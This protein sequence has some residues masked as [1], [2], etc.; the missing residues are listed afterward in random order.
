[1]NRVFSLFLA[2]LL[3]APAILADDIGLDKARKAAEIFLT[4]GSPETRGSSCR[5]T[6]VNA[7]EV[8]AT[9][10]GNKPAYYIFNREGGGFV[11]ISAIDAA[12]PVLAYSFENSFGP[13]DQMPANV[14][15]WLKGYKSQ[16][17]SR[18]ISGKPA[19]AEESA[20]WNALMA[21]GRKALTG[22][23][24]DLQTADWGQGAPYNG[25]C[26]LDESGNRTVVGCTNTAISEVM[27]Y[28][29][30]P[31]AGT[32]TLPAYTSRFGST[33][34]DI[35]SVTLGEE[36]KWDKMLPNYSVASYT[37]EQADAV[38][39]LCYHVA[40]MT[41]A[42]FSAGATSASASKGVSRLTQYFGYDLGFTEYDSN[43]FSYDGWFQLIKDCI[44]RDLPV[45][46]TGYSED[47]GGHCF[48]V[49]GYD[50]A[51]RMLINFGWN[52][53]SNGYYEI[54]S[55][56]QYVLDNSCW[57][58]VHPDAG[59]ASNG[60]LYLNSNNSYSGLTYQSGTPAPGASI[61]VKFGIAYWRSNGASFNGTVNFKMMGRDGNDKCWVHSGLSSSLNN[62][63]GQYWSSV[64]L[65]IPSNVT[66]ERGDYIAAYYKD[67]NS[68]QWEPVKY[69]DAEVT[70]IGK[71]Y[72]HIADFT[73]MEFN[74]STR[75]LVFKTFSDASYTLK[76][77]SG[78]NVTSG[79]SYSGGKLTVDTRNL[80][81]GKYTVT[82]TSG[83]QSTTLSFK[84]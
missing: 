58:N 12:K 40:V 20:R 11:I 46:Y 7:S 83:S 6:L 41:Q 27:Y 63:Q 31:A 2:L 51:G 53:S 1:M 13:V 49:D 32:G 10:V 52:A 62:N 54:G 59:G 34:I 81:S 72:C 17:D 9:R 47:G 26:P 39:T 84:I 19:T 77:T 67:N 42:L 18:R 75:V 37:Q 66:I 57:V 33:V 43:L 16:I 73:S 36:Y 61:P 69:E 8:A 64:T 4:Q 50:D 71:L 21:S 74:A 79:V 70:V 55:F 15:S 29:Q 68:S 25:K 76:D 3:S 65:S 5:L 24:K 45:I 23:G 56:G 30:H 48:V 38:A 80:S 28:H 60:F 78:T 44:D 82:F 14:S 22:G 35:P